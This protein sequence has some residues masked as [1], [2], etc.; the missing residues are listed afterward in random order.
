MREVWNATRQYYSRQISD[1]SSGDL[2]FA[3]LFEKWVLV[4]KAPCFVPFGDSPNEAPDECQ[5]IL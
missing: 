1:G 5:K 4:A 2:Y 3:A